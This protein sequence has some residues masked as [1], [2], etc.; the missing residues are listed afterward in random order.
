M[1]TAVTK[2][3]VDIAV[4]GINYRSAKPAT[5][6]PGDAYLDVNND[7]VYVFDGIKWMLMSGPGPSISPKSLIPTSEELQKYPALKA[8]WE[9]YMTIRKLL[10]I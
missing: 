7:H 9:E 10:G 8:S 6:I 2:S 1:T 3:Y 5:P 4:S